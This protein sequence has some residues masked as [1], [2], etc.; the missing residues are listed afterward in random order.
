[1]DVSE[2]AASRVVEKTLWTTGRMLAA[3]SA[4]G[5]IFGSGVQKPVPAPTPVLKTLPVVTLLSGNQPT[6][7][8]AAPGVSKK[9]WFLLQ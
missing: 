2:R 7:V 6:A 4:D 9:R 5:R 8:F 1:L 3:R